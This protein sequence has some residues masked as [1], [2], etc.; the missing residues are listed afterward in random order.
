MTKKL[1]LFQ[2]YRGLPRDMYV[3]FFGRI[4][5]SMGSMIRPMLTLILHAKL[6]MNASEIATYQ[7]LFALVSIPGSLFG[8]KLA[9][10]F[11]KKYLIIVCDII[12]VAGY[13]VCAFL[14]LTASVMWIFFT[15][16]LFQLVER[17][18]YDALVADLTSPAQREHAYSL[19]YLGANLGLVLAPTIGGL[20][21]KNYLWLAFLLTGLSIGSSTL[22]IALFVRNARSVP[23]GEISAPEYE[24]GADTS[25]VL[26]V[27]R[28][29]RLLLLY[30]AIVGLA[31]AVYAQFNYL[32]PLDLSAVHGA[33]RGAVLFGSITSVNC[34][35]VVLFTSLITRRC[36]HL[37]EIRKM[38]IGEI[39][40]LLGFLVFRLFLG[41][42]W[43][44]YAAMVV[45]TLGEIFNTLST[46]PYL[47]RRIPASH[48]G[49]LFSM[50]TVIDQLFS[51]GCLKLIGLL[52]D[53][54]GSLASWG[55]ILLLGAAALVLE[56]V[57]LR[58]D[59]RRFPALYGK[60]AA[61]D[62]PAAQV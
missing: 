52:Y 45:F 30:L 31:S 20:L 39:L 36:G 42:S 50:I 56:A 18:A 8:G 6:G 62:P 35:V 34:I 49:R 5:T 15:A 21:F 22:L 11:S 59:R 38:Q 37:S 27:L 17:P 44:Y 32:M 10:R 2:E 13:I 41:V 58:Q 28:E 61:A 40:T 43:I 53:A 1:H 33:D 7:F 16:S 55:V 23:A 14:P 9:D 12:S 48:R 26:D 51:A 54:R 47:T 60:K 25:S 24:R 4:V 29:N 57:L 3:L 46:G 19:S